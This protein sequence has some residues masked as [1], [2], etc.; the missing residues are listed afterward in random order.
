MPV[1]TSTSREQQQAHLSPATLTAHPH[2]HANNY[3]NSNSNTHPLSSLPRDYSASLTDSNNN[4]SYNDNN[5]S[6][7]TNSLFYHPN[8]PS[9][10]TMK[11]DRKVDPVSSTSTTTTTSRRHSHTHSLEK[12]T[13]AATKT[14]TSNSRKRKA[15]TNDRRNSNHFSDDAAESLTA[16]AADEHHV[17]FVKGSGDSKQYDKGADGAGGEEY[18]IAVSGRKKRVLVSPRPSQQQQQQLKQQQGDADLDMNSDVDVVTVDEVVPRK[19]RSGARSS[20]AASVVPDPTPVPPV[21]T[22]ATPSP[23]KK[24]SKKIGRAHV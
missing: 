6:S 21:E 15:A 3:N 12:N 14:P 1:A 10:T 13:T 5:D 16:I 22:V 2:T 18:V 7:H 20:I 9:G 23:S 24:S 11:T 17:R 19:K 8:N 4:N